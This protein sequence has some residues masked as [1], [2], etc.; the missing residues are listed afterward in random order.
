MHEHE[1]FVPT[2]K[3]HPPQCARRLRQA[4][5]AELRPPQGERGHRLH[6][7]DLHQPQGAGSG[8]QDATG[9]ETAG[10]DE[11]VRRQSDLWPSSFFFV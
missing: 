9:Q 7:Q 10:R 11:E 6:E 1:S 8:H 5:A 4:E 2:S 3:V